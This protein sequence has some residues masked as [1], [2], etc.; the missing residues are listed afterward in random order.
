VKRILPAAAL[1]LAVH[2]LLLGTDFTR[3]SRKPFVIPR[4]LPV[5]VILNAYARPK[6]EPKPPVRKPLPEPTKPPEV[7]EP[8]PAKAKPPEIIQP[9]PLKTAPK[10]VFK[11]KHIRRKVPPKQFFVK[12]TP[13]LLIKSSP[14]PQTPAGPEPAS[15]DTIQK[16]TLPAP[17]PAKSSPPAASK[18]SVPDARPI[19]EAKPAY[20]VNPPP[21]YPRVARRK[22]YQGTVVL[23]VRVDRNGSVSDIR[24]F[25]SSRHEILDRSA[26]EAVKKWL[27]EPGK[28]GDKPV[29]MWVKVPVRFRLK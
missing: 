13:T 27:F 21:K 28:K 17:K 3:F 2:G 26:M 11:P 18:F 15:P 19:P 7:V 29:D 12:K 5:T 1:A 4:S 22:R 14:K 8:P 10:P 9:L 24:L 25:Q 16:V 23:E 20:R 6:P